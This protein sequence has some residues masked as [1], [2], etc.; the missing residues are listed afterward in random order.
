MFIPLVHVILPLV[1]LEVE[2]EADQD[3]GT[4][5]GMATKLLHF[6]IFFKRLT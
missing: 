3:T 6:F 4:A 1:T 2:V 5:A